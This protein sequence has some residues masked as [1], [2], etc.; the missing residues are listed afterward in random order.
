MPSNDWAEQRLLSQYG[1]EM[2]TQMMH[3]MINR[4]GAASKSKA[5]VRKVVHGSAF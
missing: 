3:E 2:K 1:N 4:R 5:T